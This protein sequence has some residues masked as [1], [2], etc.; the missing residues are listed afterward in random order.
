MKVEILYCPDCKIY[1]L[2]KNCP[3]C[4]RDTIKNIP[5]KFTF[6]DKGRK[7][8]VEELK[9]SILKQFKE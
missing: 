5:P 3:K 4:K 1:T 9:Q 6:E 8:R 7:Y 2:E